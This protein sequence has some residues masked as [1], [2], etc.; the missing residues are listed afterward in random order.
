[1]LLVAA[2]QQILKYRRDGGGSTVNMYQR[3]YVQNKE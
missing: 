1:M 2:P 3:L